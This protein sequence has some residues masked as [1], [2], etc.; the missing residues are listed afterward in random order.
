MIIKTNLPKLFNA[1]AL[2]IAPFIFVIPGHAN[3][4][5]LI[6]HEK[7]HFNEQLRWLILPWWIAYLLNSSFRLRAE[8]RGYK[9]Q[10]N[11]GGCSVQ[12]AA[13]W[14]STNYRLNI[15]QQQAEQLL[16]A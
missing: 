7:V 5:A 3:D 11:Q 14:L 4:Q 1:W 13:L 16:A 10:I 8:V 12:Q 9:V 15:T 6:A 2:T